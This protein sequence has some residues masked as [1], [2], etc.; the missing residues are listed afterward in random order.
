MAFNLSRGDILIHHI[1]CAVNVSRIKIDGPCKCD[2]AIDLTDD[3]LPIRNTFISPITKEDL[4]KI[5]E[6]ET[7]CHYPEA[8]EKWR[9]AHPHEFCND[10]KHKEGKKRNIGNF[11]VYNIYLVFNQ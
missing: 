8:R 11:D 4:L 9:W 3:Q 5:L 2:S 7:Y 1:I 10:N 6:P